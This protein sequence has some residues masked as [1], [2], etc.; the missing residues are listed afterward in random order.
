MA[1]LSDYETVVRAGINERNAIIGTLALVL[2]PLY[3]M[4]SVTFM[5]DIHG[6]FAIVL[7]LYGCLRALQSST[8]RAA[9]GWLCFAVATNAIC[10]TSRQLAWLGVLVMVPSTLWLLRARHRVLVG[11]AIATFA[12][13]LFILGCLHWLKHQPYTLP[14]HLLISAFPVKHVVFEFIRFFLEFPFLLLPVMVLFLFELRKRNSYAFAIV[15]AFVFAY[16]F[17]ATYPN[18]FRERLRQ[19]QEP[20]SQD[21]INV[22]GGYVVL[23]KGKPAIFLYP[24]MQTLLTVAAFGGLIGLIYLLVSSSRM[25]HVPDSARGVSWKEL[26]VLLAPFTIAYT[27]FLISRAVTI[28]SEGGY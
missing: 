13:V 5:S 23:A 6:L 14:E 19:L 28:A 21:W 26:G 27:V 24:W 18:H 7:C 9:I 25:P 22:Y 15:C 11:G 4:L 2:S 3:L 16:L 1:R 20:T 17:L 10:G 8:T 12:G